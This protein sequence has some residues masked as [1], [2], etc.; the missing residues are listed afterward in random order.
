M[1]TLSQTSQTGLQKRSGL[2]TPCSSLPVRAI[3]GQRPMSGAVI[4]DDTASYSSICNS[5]VTNRIVSKVNK[6][7]PCPF[8]EGVCMAPAISMDSGHIDSDLNLGIT[9]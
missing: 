2:Q 4:G 6:T 1:I 7:A 8:A 5:Y 9:A 3:E